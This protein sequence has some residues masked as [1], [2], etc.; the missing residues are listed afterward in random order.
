MRNEIKEHVELLE[1]VYEAR[2]IGNERLKQC[3]DQMKNCDNDLLILMFGEK[4]TSIRKES[5]EFE[6]VCGIAE[7]EALKLILDALNK[8]GAL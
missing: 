1:N 7:V 8:K 5:Q 2:R 4:Y 6:L 3:I